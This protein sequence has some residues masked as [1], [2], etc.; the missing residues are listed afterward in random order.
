MYTYPEALDA[1]QRLARD[2]FKKAHPTTTPSVRVVADAHTGTASVEWTGAP[3][4]DYRCDV[5]IHM[6]VRKATTVMGAGEF[7][8]WAAY[9]LHEVGH[10]L[11]TSK[12]VWDEAVAHNQHHL[13]N[14]LEDVREEKATI[15]MNLAF[16]AKDAFSALVDSLGAKA[17]AAKFNP[18]N[19]RN[20][21][22]TMSSLGRHANGYTMDVSYITQTLDPKGRVAKVLVWA[23]PELAKCAST[24]DCLTLTRKILVALGPAASEPVP[25][26]GK[27][28][29]ASQGKGKADAPAGAKGEGKAEEG[30][31]GAPE[32]EGAPTGSTEGKDEA[33]GEGKGEGQAK[34]EGEAQ[35]SD[36][37]GGGAGGKALTDSDIKPVS[38]QPNDRDAMNGQTA[39]DFE[40]RRSEAGLIEQLRAAM[41]GKTKAREITSVP[42]SVQMTDKIAA[43]AARMG[44]QRQLLAKALKRNEVDTYEGNRTHGRFNTRALA[45]AMQGNPHVFG[46]RHTSEG[47]DTDVQV[48]VDGSGSMSGSNIVAASTLALVVAQ[49]A[50]QVGVHCTAH[51]F[52]DIGLHEATKGK[53]KPAARKFGAMPG[54]IMGG[55]PL[56]ENLI[57]V[58]T[59]QAQRAPGKRRVL[60]LVTDGGCNQ[61]RTILKAA[62]A[63]VEQSMGIE[64]ANLHIGSQVLGVFRNEVAVN[65]NKVASS[66]LE[67]FTQVMERGL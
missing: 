14:A 46:K 1:M 33:T 19:F 67:R 36:A 47:F 2:Y 32:G 60:F 55:T 57:R 7:D 58:A 66:G 35:A 51:L 5:T 25:P 64:I 54:H 53:T 39:R 52:N 65:V 34:G 61:G 37:Q 16:N 43:D 8:H 11:H 15:D 41:N 26:R 40:E 44:R 28:E 30:S 38:V 6:P 4:R 45:K 27:P 18:N 62:G 59:A 24:R 13:L 3:G 29:G 50:A 22:W 48:L 21:G 17:A 42:G 23:M 20:I 49:A 63:Y 9:M 10:P 56:T 31:E 12:G